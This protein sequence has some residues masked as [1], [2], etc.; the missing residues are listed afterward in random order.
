MISQLTGQVIQAHI[1]S[2][3]LDVGGVGYELELPTR[4]C[5][6]V[7]QASPPVT[8]ITHLVVRE[9]AQLLFGFSSISI[10]DAFRRL[11]K[12]SGVGPKCAL[13]I[14][15]HLTV[16][17]LIQCIEQQSVTQLTAVKGVG[18]KLAQRLIVELKGAL[19]HLGQYQTVSESAH[20]QYTQLTE[21]KA[22]LLALGYRA[23]Q[24]EHAVQQVSM[25]EGSK[26]FSCEI[27]IK[28][29]LRYLCGEVMR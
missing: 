1:N 21:V 10:R 24:I 12:A 27:W 29:A 7:T 25:L 11:I 15:S 17:D 3:V 14:L 18:A 22:A 20:T 8:V 26:Q 13:A 4:C 19:S 28:H 2:V 5:S 9:D 23:A 16:E 6:V